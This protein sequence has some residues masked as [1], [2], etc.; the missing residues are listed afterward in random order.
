MNKDQYK[1]QVYH[2]RYMRSVIVSICKIIIW[3]LI[4]ALVASI[5]MSVV[6]QEL[7]SSFGSSYYSSA[8]LGAGAIFALLILI[9]ATVAFYWAVVAEILRKIKQNRKLTEY[10]DEY[11]GIS[12]SVSK[13]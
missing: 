5:I 7:N 12:K 9:A 11:L 8:S 4:Y 10:E 13:E 6:A 2:N 3:A 1:I